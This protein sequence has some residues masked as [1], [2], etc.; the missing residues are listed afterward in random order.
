MKMILQ[1]YVKKVDQVREPYGNPN[2]ISIDGR[3]MYHLSISY[4]FSIVSGAVMRE[5]EVKLQNKQFMIMIIKR[6]RKSFRT[7]LCTET[8]LKQ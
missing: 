4:L 3:Y 8:S 5:I 2:E 1:E 6:L 7:W